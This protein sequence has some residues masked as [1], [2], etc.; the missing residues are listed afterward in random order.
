MTKILV[1]LDD[2]ILAKAAAKLGT[3]TKKDTI[4]RA[5]ELATQDRLE[6]EAGA[7]HWDAWADSVGE[8]LAEVDWD[9]A[10]R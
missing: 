2:H 7:K 1:D 4:G 3:T 5:L 9:Q 6:S 10:W 8:R